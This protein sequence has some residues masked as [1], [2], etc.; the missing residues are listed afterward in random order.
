MRR[1]RMSIVGGG[2]LALILVGLVAWGRRGTTPPAAAPT[3]AEQNA[4]ASYR[5]ATLN[6]EL[7]EYAIKEYREGIL[8][9]TAT[10]AGTALE[11]AEP[12]RDRLRWATPGDL[13][14]REMP[15]LR[16]KADRAAGDPPPQPSP[17]RGLQSLQDDLLRARADEA[18]K[19]A[20]YER[21][22][23]QRG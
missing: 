4:L 11:Q 14:R 18:V 9:P 7:A 13:P 20:L 16:W 17:G 3:I 15:T 23:A 5:Q 12:S 19:Q 8:T 2:L 22:R 21:E 10:G 1:F 6:R